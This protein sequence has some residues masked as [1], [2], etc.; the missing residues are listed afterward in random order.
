MSPVTS[1]QPAGSPTWSPRH[2]EC[3]CYILN[4]KAINDFWMD[5]LKKVLSGN[6]DEGENGPGILEVT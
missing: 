2:H 5:K 4:K 6:D 1:R 3:F